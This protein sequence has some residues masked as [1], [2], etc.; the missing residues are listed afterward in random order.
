MNSSFFFQNA[1]VAAVS[2][3]L[4]SASSVK[5]NPNVFFTEFAIPQ[6]NEDA[7]FIEIYKPNGTPAPSLMGLKLCNSPRESDNCLSLS[8]ST[9]SFD[10]NGFFILCKDKAA[11]EAAYIDKTC[12]YQWPASASDWSANNYAL[13]SLDDFFDVLYN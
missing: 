9:I 7:A 4:F 12:Q 5:G 3:L 11:F 6:D 2:F 13:V 8:P 1:I 10:D